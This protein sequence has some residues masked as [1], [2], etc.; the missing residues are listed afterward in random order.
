MPQVLT[1]AT[2]TVPHSSK[3]NF[4]DY[5]LEL[6]GSNQVLIRIHAA[7]INPLDIYVLKGLYPVKPQ[8]QYKGEPILGFDGVGEVL[9]CGEAV[10]GLSR[11]DIVVPKDYGLGTWRSH[12]VLD[13]GK[14]QKIPRPNDMTVGAILK[15]GVIPAYLLVED[16]ATLKPGDWI[17]LNAAT[18]VIAQ[19]VV[20]FARRRGVHTISVIRDRDVKEVQ[21]VK[22]ALTLL[23]ADLVLTEAE[24]AKETTLT[25]KRLVLALDSVFGA[26]G[27]LLL[28]HLSPGGTFVQLGLLGGPKGKLELSTGDLFARRI[29]LRGF[30]GSAQLAIRSA[31]EQLDLLKWLV[32]LFN[33]GDLALPTLGLEKVEWNLKDMQGSERRILEAVE[34]VESGVLGQRKVIMVFD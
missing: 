33:L 13:A 16:M 17:I 15:L 8:H 11:G 22:D 6:I 34:K 27:Q 4:C 19:F 28:Q 5:E 25:T 23:G 21:S 14:V 26:S 30:R 18:S 9:E 7:P 12:A 10:E 24:L 20:Q 31:Q 32:T 3:V 29:T 2:E 1:Q